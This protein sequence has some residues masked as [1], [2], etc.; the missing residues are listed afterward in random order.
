MMSDKE[1][2][3]DEVSRILSNG[4]VQNQADLLAQLQ[5]RGVRINQSTLSR[6]LT[7]LGAKKVGGR[8][9]IEPDPVHTT[10][11]IVPA[12]VVLSI[13]P[14]GPHM[15]VIRTA[16]GQAQ[17]VAIAIESLKE[18]PIVGTIAGDDT[19]FVATRDRRT[20]TVAIRRMRHWF[21]EIHA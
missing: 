15:V 3:L 20:Q 11:P 21:G 2:R 7:E 19:V 10:G 1:Q 12:G 8:Y 4:P 14:C 17:P 18:S 6:D 5:G 13:T 16:V 9:V